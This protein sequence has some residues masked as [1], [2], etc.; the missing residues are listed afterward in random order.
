MDDDCDGE[1]DEGTDV[2]DDDGDGYAELAGDC[3]DGDAAVHP[4]AAELGNGVDDDC[5]GVVD[6]DTAYSDDDGDGF[7][8]D[9]GDCDDG[10]PTVHPGAEEIADGVDGDCDGTVDEGTAAHDDD[11]D[12]LSEDDGDC[13][14]ADPWTGPD[15][16]ELCDGLDNDCD[17][18]TDEGCATEEVGDDDEPGC[19]VGRGRRAA[20]P[21]VLLALAGLGWIL[22]RRRGVGPLALLALTLAVAAGCGSDVSISQGVRDLSVT[23][24]VLDVG[25]VAVGGEVENELLLNNV[26]QAAVTIASLSVQGE[27]ADAF[28][29]VGETSLT[30]ER[31]SSLAVGVRFAPV[32]A[33]LY[34]AELAVVSDAGEVTQLDVPLRGQGVDPAVQVYPLVLD[35][36]AAE[37]GALHTLPVTL[38]ADGAVPVLVSALELDD[39]VFSLVLPASAGEP[40]FEVPAGGEVA[41]QV[42]LVP[43]DDQPL[44]ASLRIHTDDP[45]DPQRSVALLAN[46][47]QGSGAA[48]LDADGDGTSPCGGDC[49]DGDPSVH[50]GATE[51]LDGVDND[52][53][54]DVDDGTVAFDDDGD[55]FSEQEGDCD[56][57]SDQTYP[58]AEELLDGRDNDCDGE[59]DDGTEDL[60]ADGDGF[61]E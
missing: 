5:D 55:G 9:G 30:V 47:C 49:D 51:H 33:G 41:I 20:T 34:R 52:C 57:T 58:G 45:D 35:F 10:D 39:D 18:E 7:T 40:P 16:D 32:T 44:E 26:G 37:A 59:V 29:L 11:G 28:E 3:D 36:G 2:V 14:D 17:G 46:V 19:A 56:D 48:A 60:D 43:A 6:E 21:L 8:D 25:P 22:I 23:P 15:A 54:G 24:A 38:A 4:D 31:G 61:A 12:G 27:D 53:D 50:P 13:D 1:V 42:E